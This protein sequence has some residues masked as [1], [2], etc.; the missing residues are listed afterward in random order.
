MN[1]PHSVAQ[2][3]AENVTLE[4]ECIDRMYL[5]CYVPQLTSAAGVASYFR[6]YKGYRFASTKEAVETSEAFRRNVFDFA[7]RQDIADSGLANVADDAGGD[8]LIGHPLPGG[9]EVR[10][11]E[12]RLVEFVLQFAELFAGEFLWPGGRN[13]WSGKG[14]GAWRQVRW[15]DAIRGW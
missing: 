1:M 4:L 6:N 11:G 5:N 2:L 15:A 14:G 10:F 9:G 8:F 7:K 13:C 12:A 3:Q